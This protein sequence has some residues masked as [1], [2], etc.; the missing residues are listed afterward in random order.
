VQTFVVRP[1]AFQDL[2][3]LHEDGQLKV[4][5]AG[6]A[7]FNLARDVVSLTM[8]HDDTGTVRARDELGR[9]WLYG[10]EFLRSPI[11]DPVE[12]GN[13]P[14]FCLDPPSEAEVMRA[15]RMKTNSVQPFQRNDLDGH[16]VETFFDPASPFSN[17]RIA[18]EPIVDDGAETSRIFPFVGPARLHHCHY[19][20]TI[21][22]DGPE[23]PDSLVLFLD[24]DHLIRE[25]AI[26]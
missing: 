12:G 8:D 6:Y 26:E 14:L 7:W 22:F 20:C 13:A 9:L 11:L 25:P 17:F 16:G 21:Y 19:R 2:Y 23:G 15:V 1:D 24:H 3:V 18:V 4:L 5:E 10:S